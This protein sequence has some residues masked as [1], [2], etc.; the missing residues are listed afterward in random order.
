ME[1]LAESGVQNI[2]GSATIACDSNLF[3][4]DLTVSID[5]RPASDSNDGDY[6]DVQDNENPE[7]SLPQASPLTV[8]FACD[9]SQG[10]QT[11]RVVASA[12]VN[13]VDVPQVFSTTLTTDC[14]SGS[15]GG[16]GGG[17]AGGSA[18]GSGG[19]DAG[20]SAG[21]SGGGSAGGSAG[22]SG[23][24]SGSTGVTF[25][26]GVAGS[27]STPTVKATTSGGS[28]N[29]QT[30]INVQASG[31]IGSDTLNFT[32]VVQ[33]GG[34]FQTGTFIGQPGGVPANAS[35]NDSND[36]DT[37]TAVYDGTPADTEG[38]FTLV[39]TSTGAGTPDNFGTNYADAHGSF[40][41]TLAASGG[42]LVTT[43][44]TVSGS[45]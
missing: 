37:W 27:M 18:G 39:I 42:N 11:Y 41:G 31:T 28:G 29:T 10:S 34:A 24:G 35:L 30:V 7:L 2:R 13:S 38:S 36:N 1:Q 9:S 44:T 4:A 15:G 32:A 26:G 14:T 33:L 3:D 22:G 20:G 5:Q 17:S 16:S 25:T 12:V 8:D 40:S 45:F 21:G 43:A 23:G 6:I 19:G